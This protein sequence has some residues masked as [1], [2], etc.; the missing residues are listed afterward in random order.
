MCVR[1]VGLVVRDVRVG[2]IN[3]LYVK[4]QKYYKIVHVLQCVPVSISKLA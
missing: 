3:V 1:D 2:L 4:H